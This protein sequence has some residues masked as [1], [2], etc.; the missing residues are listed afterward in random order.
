MKNILHL[1]L[2]V[3]LSCPA[4]AQYA[5]NTWNGSASDDWNNKSNWSLDSIPTPCHQVVIP[6]T[7]RDPKLTSD[8]YLS[9]L[10]FSGGNLVT[11]DYSTNFIVGGAGLPLIY[12]RQTSGPRVF[13]TVYT[14]HNDPTKT[15]ALQKSTSTCAPIFRFELHPGD[16]WP[17]DTGSTPGSTT[18][19]NRQNGKIKERSELSQPN[20]NIPFN[21][22][23]DVTIWMAYSMYIEPGANVTYKLKDHFCFLGQWHGSGNA[24]ASWD[25]YFR[26]QDSLVLQTRG[27]DLFTGDENL[28]AVNRKVSMVSRGTWHD[29]VVKVTHSLKGTGAVQWWLDGEEQCNINN[30]YVGWD[31]TTV[32][33]WKFGIYRTAASSNVQTDLAIRYAN[34]EVSTSSLID[35]VANPR[36]LE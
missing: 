9:N 27:I 8:I 17:S 15:Y 7:P 6:T 14:V 34:M 10:S 23:T 30:I 35:R 1:F 25:F 4:T 12:K 29:F 28:L 3:T 16:N 22:T 11:N 13:N 36:P 2:F 5:Q 26:G 18:D 24:D 31:R 21:N 33:Y 19:G 32:G 20:M